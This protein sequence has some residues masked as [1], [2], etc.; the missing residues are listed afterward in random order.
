[1]NEGDDKPATQATRIPA[2]ESLTTRLTDAFVAANWLQL[3]GS[4]WR[5]YE[6]LGRGAIAV[7][8][9]AVTGHAAGS[10]LAF[11]LPYIPGGEPVERAVVAYDPKLQIVVLFVD[12]DDYKAANKGGRFGTG[13]KL[14]RS[15]TGTPPPPEVKK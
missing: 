14:V 8:W 5:Q 12:E 11:S 3:A 1:M 4:A 6:R 2:D 9:A 10:P 7:P 15:F 13:T